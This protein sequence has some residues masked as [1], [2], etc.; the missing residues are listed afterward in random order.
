LGIF[1]MGTSFITVLSEKYGHSASRVN[2]LRE[3]GLQPASAR[4]NVSMQGHV[5]AG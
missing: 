1:Q 2:K 5:E 3:R 4:F